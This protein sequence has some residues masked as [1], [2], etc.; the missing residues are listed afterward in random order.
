MYE[1]CDKHEPSTRTKYGYGAGS[2]LLA[3]LSL[4]GVQ[5]QAI[6]YTA[7][8]RIASLSPGIQAPGGQ[9]IT[10]LS[11]NQDA[12]L[13]AVNASG[14]ALASYTYD[15]FG[16]R[17]VKTISGT[18]GNIYQ[19]GQNG[20]LLEETNASGAAQ[21][22]YIYLNGRPI[23]G[24]NNASGAIARVSGPLCAGLVF[25]GINP[26]APFVVS[27]LIVLPAIYLALAAGRNATRGK[28][29]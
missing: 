2:G 1:N 9:T 24:L 7:D 26:S 19:Y 28:P 21:A 23:A 20:M 15:A 18:T 8:G 11:Y 27:S 12:Q 5:T 25:A 17:L 4:G 6:G 14:G 29:L 16:Q 13:A 3:T 22:D 10:S